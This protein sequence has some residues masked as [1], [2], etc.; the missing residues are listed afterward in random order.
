VSEPVRYT[1]SKG[2]KGNLLASAKADAAPPAARKR[3]LLVAAAAVAT[4]TA[5]TTATAGLGTLARI[6]VWKWVAVGAVGLGTVVAAKAVVVPAL[7]PQAQHEARPAASQP[8][9]TVS[10]PRPSLPPV[11]PP[12]PEP[13]PVAVAPTVP[14]PAPG[15]PTDRS[16]PSRPVSPGT[17]PASAVTKEV[18]VPS[19]PARPSTLAAEIASL[20][21]AKQA[22][23]HADPAEA[24]RQLDAYRSAFPSGRLAAEAMALRVEALVRAGRRDDARVELARLRAASPDSPL[25]E[26]L[27]SV[28]GD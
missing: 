5:A 25:L 17:S 21:G 8:P 18:E 20:D 23:A 15:S 28:V 6:A 7:L 1:A 13:P 2:V 10:H 11:D 9:P 24:L 4:S 12:P 22:L 26:N 16:G 3:A 19:S 27:T 14:A